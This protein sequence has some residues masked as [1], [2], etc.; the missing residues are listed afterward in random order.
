MLKLRIKRGQLVTS[1][2]PNDSTSVTSQ[3]PNDSMFYE[4]LGNGK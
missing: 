3:A 4:L 2:A 1:Q